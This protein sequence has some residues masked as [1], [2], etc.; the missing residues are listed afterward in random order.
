MTDVCDKVVLVTGGARG[1]GRL[2]ASKL[3]GLGASVVIWDIDARR[4]T[5]VADNLRA[6]AHCKVSSYL[7]DVA[8]PSQ[9]YDVADQVKEEVGAVEI[10]IHNAGVVSGKMFH[11]CS[12]D[13]IRRTIEVNTM[14]VFWTTRAFLP[15]MIQRGQGHLVTV[16]SA[17]ALVGTAD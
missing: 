9:V 4:L 1:I 7:C 16:A 10:L 12:D 6:S 17:A 3:A 11:K 15:E 14:S 2:M 8:D 5:E 13:Q